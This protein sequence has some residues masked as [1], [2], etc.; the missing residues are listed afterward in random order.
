MPR[1]VEDIVYG[2]RKSIRNVPIDG[3][4][5]P[6]RK[7]PIAPP[8]LEKKKPRRGGRGKRLLF[9]LLGVVVVLGVGAY[10]A[11]TYFSRALFTIVPKEIPVSISGVYVASNTPKAGSLS[12]GLE[13]ATDEM[14]VDVAAT[15][16]TSIE[17]KARGTVTLYN[18]HSASAWRLVAGTRLTDDGG[19]SVYRLTGSVS[20]PGYTK[21][22]SGTII[23]GKLNTTVVADKAGEEYNIDL[24]ATP[25]DFSIVAYKGTDKYQTVY[26]KLA[27]SIKG[28]L[29]GR[30]KTVDP[31]LLASTTDNLKARLTAKL[32]DE[33]NQKISSD[34][35]IY[36]DAY[37]LS[38][39]PVSV[40][41][42]ESDKA[43]VSLKGS[44]IGIVLDR[45]ELAKKLAG[46]AA[47][48]AFGEFAY[49]APG[50]ETLDFSI[51][52]KKDFSA[53]KKNPIIMQIKGDM[54]LIGSIPT[55]EL[56]EK[57][58]GL[59]LSETEDILRTYSPVIDLEQSSGQV[60]PPWSRVPTDTNRIS[61]MIK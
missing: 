17:Q 2:D 59:S 58:A 28:G 32:H 44:L 21:S 10:V 20:I 19:V 22:S 57:F 33:I 14:N 38:F 49:E 34:K 37:L 23:P 41:G 45:T 50:M 7:L 16:G 30:K 55:E 51:S 46:D 60:V 6:I 29:I 47:I 15:D 25:I 42:D 35:I 1:R 5:V 8:L 27:K 4:E 18:A 43:T 61:I 11:S 36:D 12:Y 31:D 3:R 26:A 39:E 13:M 40:K 54:K 24:G 52:N 48:D 53:E 9:S 56:K